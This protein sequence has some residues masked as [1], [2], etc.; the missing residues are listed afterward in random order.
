MARSAGGRIITP[1]LPFGRLIFDA[2]VLD[3][4]RNYLNH[5]RILGGDTRLRGYPTQAFTGRD[6][7]S[8]NLEFRTKPVEILTAQIGAA[9]FYDTGDAFNDFSHVCLKQG[10]GFGLRGLLPMLD[11]VVLRADWGFPLS[12]G[13]CYTPP[14]SGGFPGEIV[15]TFLQAFPMPVLPNAG[16]PTTSAPSKE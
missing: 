2:I 14:T 10:A 13:K 11:R 16:Q 1:T 3:R 12:N 9:A 7:I 4:Y 5:K 6:L 8:T 15:V